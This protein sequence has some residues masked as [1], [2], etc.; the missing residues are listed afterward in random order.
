MAAAAVTVRAVVVED[1]ASL[2]GDQQNL[3]RPW[4]TM[5]HLQSQPSQ[6]RNLAGKAVAATG[7]A[8][9][10]EAP[11][12]EILAVA[13]RVA[14]GPA[15]AAQVVALEESAMAV[16][17]AGLLEASGSLDCAA[18]EVVPAPA[19]RVRGAVV[20]MD[21]ATL[22]MVEVAKAVVGMAVVVSG[23]AGSAVAALA[24]AVGTVVVAPV[25]AGKQ[26]VVM[27]EVLPGTVACE[28]VGSVAVGLVVARLVEAG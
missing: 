22:A 5:T 11:M 27:V 2:E 23:V 8:E 19:R 4:L 20:A 18:T 3:L 25:A 28:V 17:A 7:L 6:K 21:V 15:A 14:A 16:D 9:D 26:G 10:E 13:P 24:V 12:V 1:P